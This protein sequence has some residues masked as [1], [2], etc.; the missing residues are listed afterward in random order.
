VPIAT[1]SRGSRTGLDFRLHLVQ[2]APLFRGLDAEC[3]SELVRLA[4]DVRVA[5]RERFFDQ[6]DPASV[7]LVLCAGRVKLTHGGD[8]CERVILRVVVPG[9][10]FGAIDVVDG[11]AHRLGAQALEASHALGW[12]RCVLDAL[13][14]RQ[15]I[16]LR[17]VVRI[18]GE[19]LRSLEQ[20]WRDL[21]TV[22]VPHRVAAA[23]TRLAVQIGRPGEGGTIVALG[24]ED[25][26][27]MTGTTPFTVSRLLSDWESRGYVRSRRE[28]VVVLDATALGRCAADVPRDAATAGE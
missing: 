6:G 26:A 19:R 23:L 20:S 10:V 1:V 13:A 28:A 24:R 18:L 7:V 22:R 27:Q 8:G 17:N 9:E 14:A 4:R 21:A 12:D 15:P 5:R 25:L 2:R 11:G 3:C 16:L